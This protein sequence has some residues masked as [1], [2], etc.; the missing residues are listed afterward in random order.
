LFQSNESCWPLQAPKSNLGFSFADLVRHSFDLSSPNISI[1]EGCLVNIFVNFAEKHINGQDI[2]TQRLI[3]ANSLL[4]VFV[5]HFRGYPI[6]ELGIFRKSISQ[7][8]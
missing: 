5:A 3:F 2:K 7:F 6:W 1:P 4:F 8:F